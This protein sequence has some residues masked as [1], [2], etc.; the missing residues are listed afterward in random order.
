MSPPGHPPALTFGT[1]PSQPG[2]LPAAH[3][4]SP[5]LPCGLTRGPGRG[6]PSP[7]QALAL[8]L[9]PN[10]LRH[11]LLQKAFL[12][13]LCTGYVPCSRG[14]HPPQ[15][16]PACGCSACLPALACELKACSARTRPSPQESEDRVCP[17]DS[18]RSPLPCCNRPP[19]GSRSGLAS[20]SRPTVPKGQPPQAP[21]APDPP[22]PPAACRLRSPPACLAGGPPQ[23][24]RAPLPHRPHVRQT[25][26]VPP[27]TSQ[28]ARSL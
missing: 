9:A 20:E 4:R 6:C 2:A 19:R 8:T 17:A 27:A 1:P 7:T 18:P 10:Q 12:S 11:Q 24:A 25:R 22:W 26:P 3:N 21:K 23:A 16:L 13:P 14:L 15:L 28:P 5:S